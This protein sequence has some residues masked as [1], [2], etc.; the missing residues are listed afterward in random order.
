MYDVTYRV[1]VLVLLRF[2]FDDNPCN[3][4]CLNIRNNVDCKRMLHRYAYRSRRIDSFAAQEDYDGYKFEERLG[5]IRSK[6]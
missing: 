5:E 1:H 6:C 2:D 4:I 3:G